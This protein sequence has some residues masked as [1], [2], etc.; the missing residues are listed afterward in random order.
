M[1]RKAAGASAL[2]AERHDR[3]SEHDKPAGVIVLVI[4]DGHENASREWRLDAVRDAVQNAENVRNWRFVFL[5]AD[6]NAFEDAQSMGIETVS[7]YV[8]SPRGTV[9]LYAELGSMSRSYRGRVRAGDLR[10]RPEIKK[11]LTE[12][13]PGSEK[14]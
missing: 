4:T 2:V 9:A 6:A 10:A 3:L 8:A 5:G 14:P 13:D 12:E 1:F 11:T 7:S